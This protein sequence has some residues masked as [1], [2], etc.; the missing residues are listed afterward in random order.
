MSNEN[1]QST[2]RNVVLWIIVAALLIAVVI[3]VFFLFQFR[4]DYKAS[5]EEIENANERIS[6]RD[7]EISSLEAQL[8][9]AKETISEYEDTISD[10]E[11]LIS[12][13]IDLINEQETLITEQED[14]IS[15]L[16]ESKE[17][18]QNSLNDA[19]TQLG[20]LLCD[21]TLRNMN[22]KEIL[23]SSD[24]LAAFMSGLPWV[25]RTTYTF[26]NTLWN[27]ALSK[28][29]GVT[30]LHEDGNTYSMQFLVYYDELGFEPSTFW[31]DNQCW[32]DA[33]DN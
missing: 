10:Y 7:S 1:S 18:V 11:E 24:R 8:N 13:K 27:N 23:T 9:S 30:F 31:I 25:E 19:S 12:V 3:S 21:Q 32:V 26:R 20:N 4:G 22:Y 17:R 33:P 6:D 29:H 5:L 28:I 15:S 16:N 14:E 2:K